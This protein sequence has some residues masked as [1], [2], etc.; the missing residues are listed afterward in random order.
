[1]RTPSLLPRLLLTSALGLATLGAG[2]GTAGNGDAKDDSFGGNALKADGK[3]TECQLTEVLKRVN[4]SGS[5]SEGLRELGLREDAAD[6]IASHRAGPD[7]DFGTADDDL[8]DDLAELDA[9]DFVGTVALDY[10]VASI[11]DRCEIDLETRPFVNAETFAGTT[12]GGWSR[13]S[14]ELEA[15]MTIGGV[16]GPNLHSILTATDDRGRTEFSRIAKNRLFEAFTLEYNIDEMPWDSESHAAREGL[17]YIPLSI[18]SG[19]YE[20]DETDGSREI[21]LGTDIMDDIYYDTFDY[22][23]LKND[24]VLRG[25]ARWDADDVIRRLLIAVKFG[26]IVDE[27]GIKKAA[28][29]DIRNDGASA[30]EIASLHNDVMSGTVAWNGSRVPVEPI[31]ELYNV[32]NETVRLPDIGGHERVMVLDPKVY[33][34]S[35]RSRYHLN[36]ASAQAMKRIYSNGETRLR[37]AMALAQ[38]AIDS[39]NLSVESKTAAEAFLAKANGLLDYTL[40]AARAEAG[41]HAIDPT[42]TV[43]PDVCQPPDRLGATAP[44]LSLLQQNR[45]VAETVSALFHEL[46]N[47]LDAIDRDI[48]FTGNLGF[49][50]YVEMFH[51]WQESVTPSLRAKRTNHAFLAVYD[52]ITAMTDAE[53][54]AQIDAFNTYG[55]AQRGDGNEGFEDFDEVTPAIWVAFGRHLRFAANKEGQRQ[56]EAAG[57]MAQ[58]LWFEQARE[59]YVPSSNRPYGN[60]LI[61]TMDFTD[62]V[63]HTEWET[64]PEADRKIS[65]PLDP[66]KIFHTT[67]VNEVQI[68]LGLEKPYMERVAEM[69]E[70]LSMGAG[71]ADDQ[72]THDGALFVFNEL[73]STILYVS[74]LK[75]ERVRDRLR[76]AGAPNTTWGATEVSKGTLALQILADL[77]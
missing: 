29:M 34:R 54:N 20:L 36:L 35:V 49:D 60:F 22:Q 45:V 64:I 71:T 6:A 11:L 55:K 25:R 23:L 38:S 57:S 40:V 77:D 52:Q 30:E 21:S 18:E 13:D 50:E 62:M 15:A 61:D 16:T 4:E 69:K 41:L 53:R 66:A 42:L 51:L 68:E 26:A 24:N 70:K 47:D 9:V 48:T 17:A 14:V 46:G 37:E 72:L 56:M 1:M 3:Y 2:C 76:R 74:S 73:N 10:I 7:G 67:L 59:T 58:A 28:K 8:Y 31:R 75:E 43:T 33:L 32:L 12:G 27:N 19:R 5:T 39:G 44:S 65:I 63:T